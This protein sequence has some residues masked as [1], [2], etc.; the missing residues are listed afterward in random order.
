MKLEV[1]EIEKSVYW[2]LVSTLVNYQ[3]SYYRVT[4]SLKYMNTTKGVIKQ[5][6]K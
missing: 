3:A 4:S 2:S 1:I 5:I 6:S